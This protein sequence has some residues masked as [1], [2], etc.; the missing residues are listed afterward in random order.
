MNKAKWL[1]TDYGKGY[2]AGWIYRTYEYRGHIYVTEENRKH[3]N[4]IDEQLWMQ[5]KEEQ[6]RIDDLLDNPKP[7]PEWLTPE[8]EERQ[9]S[10]WDAIWEML[11]L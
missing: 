4:A 5:H 8:E 10:Q 6:K 2:N 11:G 3:G 1:R 9:K 7:E